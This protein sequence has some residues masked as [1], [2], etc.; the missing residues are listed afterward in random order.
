M[1]KLM[2]A[3]AALTAG[4][5]IAA[6][7]GIVSST[8]VGYQ[9]V[10]VP[11]GFS[12]ITPCF[13]NTNGEK[14]NADEMICNGAEDGTAT[15][16]VL[17]ED[18]TW[19]AQGFWFSEAIVDDVTYP[20]GWYTDMSGTTSA[21]ITLSPGQAVWFETKT[22]GCSIQ[23]AGSVPSIKIINVARGFSM[24]GN[25][26]PS[27]INADRLSVSGTE[28]G[29]TTIQVLN[30][31]GSWGTQGFWFNEASVDGVTYPAGWYTD[32]SGS[33][34]ANITLSPG[35]AVWFETKGDGTTVTIPSG[36]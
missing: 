13:A 8:V 30:D 2:M 14:F 5:V 28:D 26:T 4:F 6:D 16:Q 25:S 24:I 36:L 19:G 15:I 29:T 35:R 18:G 32:M 3:A 7:D 27:E 20:A 23:T 22:E 33:E 31:D 1:K 17:N 11:E 10:S 12:M 34:S 21:N 9:T